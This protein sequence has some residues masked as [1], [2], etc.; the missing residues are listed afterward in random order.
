MA[1]TMPE[2]GEA[3]RRATDRLVQLALAEDFGD[4]GDVTSQALIPESLSA[5]I[6]VVAR[7]SGVLAGGPIGRQVFATLDPAVEWRTLVE[8]GSVIAPGTVV[9]VVSGPF[10]SVLS[11]ERTALNFLTHLCGIASLT[12]QFVDAVSGTSV[13]LLDTRKTHPGYR[14][15]EKYAVRCGGGSNHRMGLYDG[16][17]IKDNHV[18]AWQSFACETAK[19]T[20]TLADAIVEARKAIPAGLPLEVEVDT[21]EQ[22]QTVLPASPDIVLLD[23]MSTQELS[24]AVQLRNRLSPQVRL[25]ASGGVTL[26]NLRGIAE[27]G[28]DRVSVGA[29]T[30]SAI[31]LDL[32]FDWRV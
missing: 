29:L 6:S 10:R 17:M 21:L 14:V 11:G 9:A 16:C 4:R 24:Q 30:H 22:L 15:L 2:F 13:K 23:N 31:A 28:V 19:G 12:R 7:A 27:T 18:A 20:R 25:E 3:E 32:A 5:E 26:D 8:D 1:N